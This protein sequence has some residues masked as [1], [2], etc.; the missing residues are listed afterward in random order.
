[1]GLSL[2]LPPSIEDPLEYLRR[3]GRE[4]AEPSGHA[5]RGEGRPATVEKS[6]LGSRISCQVQ[7]GVRGLLLRGVSA[8]NR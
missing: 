2:L 4:V 7:F 6:G 8:A 3:G 1:M 5:T